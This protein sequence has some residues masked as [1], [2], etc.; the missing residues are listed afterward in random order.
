MN[1]SDWLTIIAI[2]LAPIFALQIQKYIE[3]RKEIKARKMQIFRTLM[4]TRANRL[5]PAHI[6]ALN[7]IDIE[8]YKNEKIT[9]IWKSMLDN[10]ANYPQDTND[11]DYS[12]KLHSCVEKSDKLLLDL[13]LE[14]SKSLDYKFDSVHLKR[15]I[16]LPKG[17]VDIM[18]WQETMRRSLGD[19][20]AGKR[21]FP[22]Y[23]INPVK[24][25]S[26]SKNEMESQSANK[27]ENIEKEN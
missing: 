21:P 27:E 6:E 19:I 22:V 8:F 11:K 20:L 5:S 18:M 1:I 4:A 15:N 9:N 10:F 24:N 17:Q 3:D 12:V 25:T 14:M 16:Y 23:I 7:M 26:A 2:I 13:L